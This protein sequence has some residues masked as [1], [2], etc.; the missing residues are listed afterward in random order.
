MRTNLFVTTVKG[1]E[2]TASC[3]RDRDATTAP[4]HTSVINQIP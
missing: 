2:P 4:I 1:F 3:A